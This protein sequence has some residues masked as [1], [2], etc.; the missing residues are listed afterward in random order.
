MSPP[1][2]MSQL[3]PETDDAEATRGEDAAPGVRPPLYVRV[4]RGE[5]VESLHRVHV[6][7]ADA[8]GR[9]LEWAGDPGF[10]TFLRSAAKPLQALPLV[11]DGVVEALGIPDRELA[12]CCASHSSEERHVAAARGLLARAGIREEAL[13]CGGHPPLGPAQAV[14]LRDAGVAPG[15]IHSNCSGKHAGMLALAHFHGWS[16]A[17]YHL[18][19]HPVQ[20][21][22]LREV[23]RWTELDPGAI[24]VGVDGCGVPTLRVPLDRAAGALARFAAAAGAAEPAGRVVSAML[25]H[26]DMVAGRGRLCTALMRAGGG[27]LV[28][29]TGAEGVYVLASVRERVGVAVKAEDGATRAGEAAAMAV[30]TR[31]GWV[32]PE[33]GELGPWRE[34][35]VTNTRGE[36]VGRIEVETAWTTA[37]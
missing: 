20:R 37:R 36:T 10:R 1:A 6:V 31:L 35:P 32:D 14:R 34:R 29:K 22:M 12:L 7:V 33:A 24:G 11:E 28:A 25:R 15:P 4:F 19:D 13:A 9:L 18:P 16:A 5:H 8:A 21:R 2:T 26:P 27:T 3:Q 17:G 23:A 30:A